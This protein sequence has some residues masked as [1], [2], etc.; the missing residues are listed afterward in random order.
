[1][2]RAPPSLSFVPDMCGSGSR[3]VTEA[4]LCRGGSPAAPPC[5][6]QQFRKHFAEDANERGGSE[7]PWPLRCERH[8]NLPQIWERQML[9]FIFQGSIGLRRAVSLLFLSR[10]LKLQLQTV[11][12][13]SL[14]ICL[15]TAPLANKFTSPPAAP[16]CP[17]PPPF[18]PYKL[19]W[20]HV[21]PRTQSLV[22]E[23]FCPEDLT[24]FSGGDE[25]MFSQELLLA[26]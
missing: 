10:F 26:P 7:V 6:W 24:L 5:T 20:A 2:P 17:F 21:F 25:G 4:V 8:M 3:S 1:M 12:F 15:A 22:D 23:I 19:C 16:K 14:A 13:P 11:F 9:L 18:V